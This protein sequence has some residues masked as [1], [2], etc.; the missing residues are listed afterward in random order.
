MMFIHFGVG[1]GIAD[2]PSRLQ[3]SAELDCGSEQDGESSTQV[4]F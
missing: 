2:H 1:G 3:G 4:L